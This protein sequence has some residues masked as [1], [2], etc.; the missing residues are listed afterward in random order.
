MTLLG[1]VTEP[2][3]QAL[4]AANFVKLTG[5]VSRKINEAPAGTSQTE[6]LYLPNVVLHMGCAH[7]CADLEKERSRLNLARSL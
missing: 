3:L 7:R 2:A 4:G 1:P 5:L 6:D